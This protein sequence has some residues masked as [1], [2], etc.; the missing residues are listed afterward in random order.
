MMFEIRF[1]TIKGKMSIKI[2]R[3]NDISLRHQ[4][5]HQVFLP[6]HN[7]FFK[8]NAFIKSYQMRCDLLARMMEVTY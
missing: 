3:R 8:T 5:K 7:V 2:L 6:I 4:A 1:L